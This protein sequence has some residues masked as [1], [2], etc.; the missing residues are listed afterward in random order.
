M[1]RNKTDYVVI[2]L[3]DPE[4]RIKLILWG[5]VCIGVIVPVLTL[6]FTDLF[7]VLALRSPW[8]P[9]RHWGPVVCGSFGGVSRRPGGHRGGCPNVKGTRGGAVEMVA[10]AKGTGHGDAR[11]PGGCDC[12]RPVQ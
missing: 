2:A 5:L 12:T 11:L 1:S 3:L 8:E 7:L 10:D 4:H 6:L 9:M